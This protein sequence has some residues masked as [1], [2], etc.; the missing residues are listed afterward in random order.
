[1]GTTER[2][3][4]RVLG[5]VLA[6]VIL[7]P[8]DISRLGRRQ[9]ALTPSLAILLREYGTMQQDARNLLGKPLAPTDLVF[10]HSDGAL[11]RPA[12][13]IRAFKTIA[14]SLGLKGAQL[15]DLCHAHA[16]LMLQQGIHPKVVSKRL[17]HSSVAITPDTYSH[18][19]PELQEAA[20]RH[21]EEGLQDI[22]VAMP[23]IGVRQ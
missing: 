6:A 17:G 23:P 11:I 22:A 16:T 12:S 14:E 9:I 20:A 7:P 3:V 4:Y 15:H 5:E 21:F 8:G 13:V 18:I 19:L 1:M 10:S 2:T